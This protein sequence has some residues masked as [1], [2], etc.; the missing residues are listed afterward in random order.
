MD[1]PLRRP[2]ALV[3]PMVGLVLL[4]TTAG[5]AIALPAPP[6]SVALAGVWEF[7]VNITFDPSPSSD[8]IAYNIHVADGTINGTTVGELQPRPGRTTTLYDTLNVTSPANISGMVHTFLP[9]RFQNATRTNWTAAYEAG[10]IRYVPSDFTRVLYSVTGLEAEVPVYVA[11]TAV[12][13]DGENPSV[14]PVP[15]TPLAQAVLARPSNEGIYVSWALILS[16]VIAAVVVLSRRE[17]KQNRSAYVYVLPALLGLVALTFYPVLYGFFLSFTD[18]TGAQNPTQNFVGFVN[19]LTVFTTPDFAM[20]AATTLVWTVVNVF[21]H[22]T[23]GLLLAVLLNRRIRGRVAYRALL[24]LPWAVPS[25][26][27][28]LAWRGMFETQNGLINQILG[29][30]GWSLL[31]CGAT[32]CAWLTETGSVLPLIAVIITNIWL[33]IPFMMMVFSGALQGIPPELYE[34]ADVDGLTATQKFFHI[35]LPLVKPAIIPAALLGFIWTFNMFNVIYLMTQ[36]GPPVPIAGM[37]AGATDILITFVYNKGFSDQFEQGLAAAYSVVIFFMLLS[38]GLFYTWRTGAFEAFAGRAAAGP[39]AAR[40]YPGAT[41]VGALHRG[42]GRLT[43]PVR[44]AMGTDQ[45]EHVLVPTWLISSIGALG[46]FEL[47]YG[48]TVYGSMSFWF[49]LT[50]LQGLWFFVVGLGLVAAAAALSMRQRAG[51]RI[52]AW[53]LLL[54]LLGGLLLALANPFHPV[55]LRI[56]VVVALLFFLSRPVAE[57]T[58]EPDPWTRLVD[59]FARSRPRSGNPGHHRSP[60]TWTNVGVHAVL[61]AFVAFAVLPVYA[62][63]GTAFGEFPAMAVQNMPIMRDLLLRGQSLPGWTLEHFQ[64][65]LFDYP[66]SL[67]LRNSLLVSAATTAVGILLAITGSYA[68][69]RYQFRGKRASMLSFIIVQMFPGVIIL[70]PYYVLFFQLGLINTF[71]GLVIAYSVTALPFVLWFLKG[72]FDTIPVDLDEA[73]MVDGTTRTGAMWR[74]LVPLARPA[75]AVA[76]LFT[77]LAAWNEWLLAFTFMTSSTNYTLPVGVS[78]FV[79]PPQ[80]FW[81]EFAAISILVALPIVVLFIVFQKYLVSGL[82]KGAVKG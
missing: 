19:Y 39:R 71:G 69:S 42:W 49:I 44:A 82:T 1:K 24:L 16:A 29:P 11:V 17:A 7:T 34:A 81:N 48:A 10:G 15:A 37:E 12:G 25:Y 6:A 8:V 41:L 76:A 55:N 62:V 67:W 30:L 79:Y 35:T 50:A 60:R 75:I 57:Y 40:R 46:V 43:N 80:V 73:A 36:G 78:S 23:I 51:R 3:G 20:V 54:G 53:S 72:F 32:P 33:G 13:S 2:L 74:V 18:R 26:I 14:S 56:P 28:T 66:F 45:P 52:A 31:G 27:T 65:V 47:V 68:F 9:I 4:F 63:A 77:F 61:L 64:S 5:T 21:F 58:F 70:I 22:V 38:F 59:A